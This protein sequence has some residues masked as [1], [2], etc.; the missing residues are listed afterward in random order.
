MSKTAAGALPILDVRF[1]LE[2]T[3][4]MTV[5]AWIVV[6]EEQPQTTF[7]GGGPDTTIRVPAT[8][9]RVLSVAGTESTGQMW[10]RSSRGPAADYGTGRRGLAPLMAH[11]ASLN[12][13]FGTSYASPRACAD[14]AV[15]IADANKLAHCSDA[16]D[17]LCE[18]Y[19]LQRPTLPVWNRRTGF[20]KLFA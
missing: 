12:G 20:I 17:L 3:L 2:S 13:T 4:D 8:E 19:G 9:P 16:I 1:G 14:V 6:C 15:T 7:V 11:L 10:E 18:T 5:N